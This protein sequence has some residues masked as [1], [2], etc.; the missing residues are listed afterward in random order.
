MSLVRYDETYFK[1]GPG[2]QRN[3]GPRLSGGG[4]S[5]TRAQEMPPSRQRGPGGTARCSPVDDSIVRI[6]G[7]RTIVCVGRVLSAIDTHTRTVQ[8]CTSVRV[9]RRTWRDGEW[10]RELEKWCS[11]GVRLRERKTLA[12]NIKLCSFDLL[13]SSLLLLY[14]HLYFLS[15]SQPTSLNRLRSFLFHR[16]SVAGL[17]RAHIVIATKL[18]TRCACT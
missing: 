6:S 5:G 4:K 11:F 12:S 3:G 9:A 2:Q 1:S 7:V 16:I 18:P 13:S 10:R 15:S 14:L 17:A 8:T